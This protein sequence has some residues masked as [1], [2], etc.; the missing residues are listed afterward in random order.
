MK[1]IKQIADEIGVSKTAVRKRLTPEVQTKFAETVC[2]VIYI[3]EQGETLIKQAFDNFEPQ[4]KFAQ[5]SGN[6]FAV[7]SGEVSALISMLK[8][9]LEIKNRQIDD[10][11]KRLAESSERLTEINSALITAQA[12]HAGTLQIT[13]RSNIWDKVFKK[14]VD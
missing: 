8:D 14:K 3:S 9:E 7:V 5:V 11:N 4:T 6:Q 1:T 13:K 10:L 2:G 12:L